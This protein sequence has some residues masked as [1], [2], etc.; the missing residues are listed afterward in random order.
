MKNLSKTV[1]D[2]VLS[3][4]A[5]LKEDIGDH[6]MLYVVECSTASAID[7]VFNDNG[8]A[9]LAYSKELLSSYL[10]KNP[11]HSVMDTTEL[12]EL[13]LNTHRTPV[14]EITPDDFNYALEVLPPLDFRQEGGYLSFKMSEF[15]T[16]DLTSIYVRDPEGRC[17]TF[18]DQV[19][20]SASDCAQRVDAH[21][22][23]ESQVTTKTPSSSAPGM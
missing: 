21:K 17:F 15:Y 9:R 14:R 2:E 18:R 1:N 8:L 19:S 22:S 7:V 12:Y 20:L 10:E 23:T 3:R 5:T 6:A 16:A 11:G 4:L 13:T